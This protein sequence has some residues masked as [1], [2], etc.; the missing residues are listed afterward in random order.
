MDRWREEPVLRVTVVSL[1][2]GL[3][4][5]GLGAAGV[6]SSPLVVAALLVAAAGLYALRTR[7]A[8]LE[9]LDRHRFYLDLPLAPLVG[10]VVALGWLDATPGELQALGGLVG[11]VG[12]ANYF[13]RPVYHFLYRLPR[14]F[15]RRA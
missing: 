15:D 14:R 12:M 3:A 4:L 13:L 5:I 1:V 2:A 11:L 9:R 10:A 8:G 7:I 6:G